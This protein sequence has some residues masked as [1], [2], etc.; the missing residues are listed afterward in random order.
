MHNE[1]RSAPSEGEGGP[2]LAQADKCAGR[3]WPARL[4]LRPSVRPLRATCLPRPPPSV[5]G[6]QTE[7]DC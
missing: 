1:I 5:G 7:R 3:A 2:L 4:K 6:P